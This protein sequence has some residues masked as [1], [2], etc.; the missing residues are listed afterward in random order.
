MCVSVVVGHCYCQVTQ[1]PLHAALGHD[2][3]YINYNNNICF[4]NFI[5]IINYENIIIIIIIYNRFFHSAQFL[6]RDC[7]GN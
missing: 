6:C 2:Y 4:H 7:T 1:S 3:K 5:F